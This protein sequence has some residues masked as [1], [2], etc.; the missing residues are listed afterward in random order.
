MIVAPSRFNRKEDQAP[1]IVVKRLA[2]TA[3]AFGDVH[4]SA[5][6]LFHL[7][8]SDPCF[9]EGEAATPGNEE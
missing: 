2:G 7:F 1:R 3:A 6:D 8:I 4:T 5:R 9:E